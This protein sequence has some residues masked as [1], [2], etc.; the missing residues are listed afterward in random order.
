MEAVAHAVEESTALAG[1]VR[2]PVPVSDLF[3]NRVL[4]PYRP[5]ARYLQGARITAFCDPAGPSGAPAGPLVE[6][7]GRFSVTEN[8]YMNETRCF[9]AVE[10]NI[11]Y[12]QL[13]YVLFG[14][15][16]FKGLFNRQ[17]AAWYGKVNLSFSKYLKHELFSLSIV[18]V[19]GAFVKPLNCNDFTAT[20][21]VQRILWAGQTAT[22]HT[23][24]AFSDASGI[25]SHG[26]VLLSFRLL[27]GL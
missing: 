3:I 22:V 18:Q 2:M 1:P 27:N 16:I 19:E 6:I 24:I 5:H 14:Q 10:F 26:K 12:N 17:D 4:A 25:K 13:A 8:C 15:C 9:N 7:E 23:H 11:C 20:L 21:A